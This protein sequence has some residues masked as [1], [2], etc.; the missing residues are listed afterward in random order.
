MAVNQA[1]LLHQVVPQVAPRVE[2]RASMW[3]TLM[4]VALEMVTK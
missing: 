1:N 4:A 3:S 2:E